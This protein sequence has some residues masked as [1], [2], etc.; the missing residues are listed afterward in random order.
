M[1]IYKNIIGDDTIFIKD[2]KF[3]NLFAN[4]IVI[5]DEEFATRDS[6]LFYMD[7]IIEDDED[8]NGEEM[9]ERIENYDLGYE[10]N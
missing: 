1:Q 3:R 6:K 4:F 5:K 9:F 2:E 10:V 8:L 7:S